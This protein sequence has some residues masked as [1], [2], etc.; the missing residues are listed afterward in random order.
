MIRN[1]DIRAETCINLLDERETKA[2]K[3]PMIEIEDSSGYF[4]SQNQNQLKNITPNRLG[5]KLALKSFV[6]S[7][8]DLER[9][10]RSNDK[11]PSQEAS[12]RYFTTLKRL[13]GNR[14]PRQAATGDNSIQVASRQSSSRQVAE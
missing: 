9:T 3:K 12:A 4:M 8:R 14:S 2:K 7:K 10:E 5:T 13:A 1:P 6:K 11:V